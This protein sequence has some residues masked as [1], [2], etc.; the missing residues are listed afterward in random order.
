LGSIRLADKKWTS[1]KNDFCINFD[2]STKIKMC[3][4]ENQIIREFP[5]I[6]PP[7]SAKFSPSR[8]D[9]LEKKTIFLN[10]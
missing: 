8:L 4:D 2:L 1:I 10:Y 5:L 9:N 3:K 6:A 7:S